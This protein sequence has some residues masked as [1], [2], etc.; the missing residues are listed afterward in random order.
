[1]PQ[2]P[3]KFVPALYGGIILGVLSAIPGLNFLN[4][5]CCLWVL[6]G[7]FLSVYFYK[8]ALTPEMEA[9]TSSDALGLGALAGLFGAVISTIVSG[10]LLLLFGNV[11]GEMILNALKS[12]GVLEQMPPEALAGLE[13]GI[14]EG[15]FS[16]IG[17]VVNFII[18]IIFGL[19]GGLI[20]YAVFR[21][22]D[23]EQESDGVGP[24]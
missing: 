23:K 7:G 18:F 8:K 10:V 5:F 19:L 3:D 14:A 9:L 16:I 4:C 24:R 22:R 12:S 6:L 17:I 11:A 15:G 20:G 2:K 1:M 21:P 13:Q